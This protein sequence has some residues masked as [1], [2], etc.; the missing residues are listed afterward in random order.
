MKILIL[1]CNTGEGHN[2]AGKAV[3]EAALLRGHEV[4]FMDLMLLDW[5][6]SDSLISHYADPSLPEHRVHMETEMAKVAEYMALGN[7]FYSPHYRHITLDSWATL[8]EDTIARR[9]MDVSSKM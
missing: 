1:S 5:K 9:Y 6:T 3:M 7:N 2:S 8:N 4:E